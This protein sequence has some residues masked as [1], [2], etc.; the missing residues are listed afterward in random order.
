MIYTIL[1]ILAYASGIILFTQ[2]K[3]EN[4]RSKSN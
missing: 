3:K 4:K 2:E 1:F